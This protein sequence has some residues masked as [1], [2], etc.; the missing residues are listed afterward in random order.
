M[1][2]HWPQITYLTI[3]LLGSG[4]RLAKNGEMERISGVGTLIAVPFILWLL[5]EGGFFGAPA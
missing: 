2:L 3:V 1:I 5:Y 4:L